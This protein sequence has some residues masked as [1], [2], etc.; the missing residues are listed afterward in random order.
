LRQSEV[1]GF[2]QAGVHWVGTPEARLVLEGDE[3]EESDQTPF[4]A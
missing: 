2:L 1:L 4:R 3:I